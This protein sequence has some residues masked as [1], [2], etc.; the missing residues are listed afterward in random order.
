[1]TDEQEKIV[2]AATQRYLQAKQMA[3]LLRHHVLE[4]QAMVPEPELVDGEVEN[5]PR[6]AE[7]TEP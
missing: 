7:D 3:D 6:D 4:L 2:R 1:M 5:P